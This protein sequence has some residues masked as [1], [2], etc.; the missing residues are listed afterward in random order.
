M[1]SISHPQVWVE[2]LQKLWPFIWTLFGYTTLILSWFLR[3]SFEGSSII[4]QLEQDIICYS[5]LFIHI[6]SSLGS[7][8]QPNLHMV[9]YFFFGFLQMVAF[10]HSSSTLL[11]FLDFFVAV[12]SIFHFQA[13]TSPP[14]SPHAL[15]SL[16]L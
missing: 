5:Y 7:R 4:L 16:L 3:W 14:I 6:L 11:L 1:L 12:F 2:L 10:C 13:P 9:L 15:L 8:S